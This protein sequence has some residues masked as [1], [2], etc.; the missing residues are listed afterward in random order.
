MKRIGFVGYACA[1][2]SGEDASAVSAISAQANLGSTF[3]VV[4]AVLQVRSERPHE[5]AS[6]A[7]P[8]APIEAIELPLLDG[9]RV[10]VIT[11]NEIALSGSDKAVLYIDGDNILTDP[12]GSPVLVVDGDDMEKQGGDGDFV[13]VRRLRVGMIVGKNTLERVKH[14]RPGPELQLW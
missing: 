4:L 8:L 10:L 3:I 2:S 11:D 14:G 7:E 9:K 5:P 13:A 1:K 6:A 12:H